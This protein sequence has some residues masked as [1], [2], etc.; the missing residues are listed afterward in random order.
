MPYTFG[1][2]SEKNLEGVIP[3]LVTLARRALELTDQ[4]FGIVDGVR[5]QAEQAALVAAG[6][7]RTMHSKHRRQDDGFGHAIDAAPYIA[8][9]TRYDMNACC[10]VAAAMREA[11]IEQ[12]LAVTWGGVWDRDLRSLPAGADGMRRAVAEYEV[13]HPGRDFIDG[14]HFQIR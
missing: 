7:S 10:H 3:S 8:G 2:K 9:R 6:A 12:G 14:P 1:A 11:A 13:R 4:D 5:E